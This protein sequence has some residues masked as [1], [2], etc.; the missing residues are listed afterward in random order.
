MRPYRGSERTQEGN[1]PAE[2]VDGGPPY[3][4]EDCRED[5][6]TLH[7]TYPYIVDNDLPPCDR[8]RHV[9]QDRAFERH[10]DVIARNSL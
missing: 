10:L 3:A 1:L 5:F 2:F 8:N 9:A 6:L 7:P 4:A